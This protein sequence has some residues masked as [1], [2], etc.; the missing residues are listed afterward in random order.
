MAFGGLARRCAEH[1]AGRHHEMGRSRGHVPHTIKKLVL[2]GC[3]HQLLGSFRKTA[4]TSTGSTPPKGRR[5][6]TLGIERA[7]LLSW[8]ARTR[9]LRGHY[10]EAVIEGERA[11]AVAEEMQRPMIIGEV[12]A[13]TALPR[14]VDDEV[15]A[16]AYGLAVVIWSAIA[17][18]YWRCS[19]RAWPLKT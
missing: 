16:R 6:V 5:G 11:L 2:S 13:D 12:L 14:M 17:K 10:R 15:L 4:R 9:S 8:I 18:P 7:R 3:R 19:P 1:L